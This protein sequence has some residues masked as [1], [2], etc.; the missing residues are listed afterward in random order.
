MLKVLVKIAFLLMLVAADKEIIH[1]Q[2]PQVW[3]KHVR[4][5]ND[6]GGSTQLLVHCRSKDN[7]LGQ[8][9]L[10]NGQY[11]GW[12]FGDN[13]FGRTLFWCYFKWNNTEKSFDIYK[14]TTDTNTCAKQ[15]WRSIR[16]DGVYFDFENVEPNAWIKVYS[17]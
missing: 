15:C 12:S 16:S 3:R 10:S 9:N 13:V 11:V 7:D 6:L 4:V 2:G 1:V 5:Q 8:H 14:T 17:W